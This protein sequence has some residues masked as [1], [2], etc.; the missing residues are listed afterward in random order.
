MKKKT[1]IL[2]MTQQQQIDGGCPD[3]T[4]AYYFLDIFLDFMLLTKELEMCIQFLILSLLFT[5]A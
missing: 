2:A 3:L 1:F 4:W 5:D